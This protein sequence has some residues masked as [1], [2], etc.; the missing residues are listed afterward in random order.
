V[1]TCDD[2]GDRSL[3]SVVQQVLDKTELRWA[4]LA[5]DYEH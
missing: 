3:P 1:F 2:P 5:T 4:D